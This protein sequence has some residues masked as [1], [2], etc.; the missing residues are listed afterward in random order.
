MNPDRPGS[1]Y[2][3]VDPTGRSS[4]GPYKDFDKG[5][6]RKYVLNPHGLIRPA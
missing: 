4:A 1:A 2:G 6:S 5:A 3:Y